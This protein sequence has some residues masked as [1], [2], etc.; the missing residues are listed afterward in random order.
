MLYLSYIFSGFWFKSSNIHAYLQTI[1][2]THSR[3]SLREWQA[4]PAAGIP[5]AAAPLPVLALIIFKAGDPLLDGGAEAEAVGD[6]G[7]AAGGHGGAGEHGAEEQA[8]E[9]IENSGGDGDA[10]AVIDKSEE[11]V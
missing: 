1:A 4:R 8:D 6:D 5:R 3:R 7:D 11:Q 10:D 2:F 9:G